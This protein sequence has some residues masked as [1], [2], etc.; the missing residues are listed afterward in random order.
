MAKRLQKPRQEKIGDG[1]SLRPTDPDFRRQSFSKR[2]L[3][4]LLGL[5]RQGEGGFCHFQ[6]K[7]PWL[8]VSQLVPFPNL[9][10]YLPALWPLVSW[11][12]L[13]YILQPLASGPLL[14]FV[15]SGMLF[16]RYFRGWL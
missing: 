12:F 11:D 4:I 1:K 6:L 3:K 14:W 5:V 16:F 2:N 10:P 9:Y 8:R 13:E 7:D 15:L